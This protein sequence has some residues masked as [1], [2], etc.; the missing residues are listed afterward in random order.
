MHAE[1][2][3]LGVLFVRTAAVA[4]RKA[5][6]LLG[7]GMPALL[8]CLP[9]SILFVRLVDITG[10]GTVDPICL[11]S[12]FSPLEKL[13][14]I[15]S[16]WFM[17]LGLMGLTQAVATLATWDAYDGKPTSFGSLASR[18]LPKLHRILGLQLFVALML[19]VLVPLSIFASPAILI[20][21]SGVFRGIGKSTDL[22]SRHA[23]KAILI[24][25]L[26]LTVVIAWRLALGPIV[27]PQGSSLLYVALMLESR[28]AMF[29]LA[30]VMIGIPTT[31]LYCQ[32]SEPLQ[33]QAQ[34]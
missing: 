14:I 7:W 18:I 13:G 6:I 17:S 21:N 34:R 12:F 11:W 19:V 29:Y 9:C 31:L 33:P 3:T 16:I 28:M 32:G 27:A 4:R 23:G 26:A 24:L 8:L 10:G 25:L 30:G 2:V 22:L 15:F 1:P 5:L 20:G